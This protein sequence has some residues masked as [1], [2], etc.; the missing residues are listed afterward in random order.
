MKNHKYFVLAVVFMS[1][2]LGV[3]NSF[4]QKRT[5]KK[6]E[7]ANIKTTLEFITG[8]MKS[9]VMYMDDKEN[10]VCPN[11][12]SRNVVYEEA[13][14]SETNLT[15]KLKD[16][17]TRAVCSANLMNDVR[18]TSKSV[19]ND[20][21]QVSIPL[22]QLDSATIRTEAC[23]LETSFKRKDGACFLLHLETFGNAK[24]IKID[25]INSFKFDEKQVNDRQQVSYTT[26]QFQIYF[27]DEE[28]ANKMAEVFSQ[29]VK[30]AGGK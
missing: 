2:C 10:A 3:S 17:L 1:L 5:K 9:Q 4:A 15:I 23:P 26:N 21:I 25:K 22:R 27:S 8:N 12:I 11:Q 20:E 24:A 14:F 18:T 6:N 28:T 29:A 13:M 16:D 7:G 30:L 19:S